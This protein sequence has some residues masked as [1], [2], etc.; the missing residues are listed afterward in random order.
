MCPIRSHT[1]TGISGLGSTGGFGSHDHR[2]HTSD[3]VRSSDL[4][5]NVLGPPNFGHVD[6]GPFMHEPRW[7]CADIYDA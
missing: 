4:P 6:G 2:E 5:P 3:P 1:R 7:F